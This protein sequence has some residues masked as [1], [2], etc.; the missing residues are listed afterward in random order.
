MCA[1]SPRLGVL[2]RLRPVPTRSVDGGPTPSHPRRQHGGRAG[3]E[4]VPVSTDDSLDEGGARLRPC[5]IAT[6][7]PQHFTEASRPDIH[8]PARKFPTEPSPGGCAPRPAH[9]RQVGAGE[10]LRDVPT[11]VPPVLLSVTL[12]GPTPS[13]G[14]GAS[15]LCQGCSHPPRHLPRQ[16]ALSFNRPAATRR[17]RRSLTSVQNVSASRRTWIEA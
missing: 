7:T 2:R 5:G 10:P 1:G 14:A 17:R 3:A 6:A 12:A 16:A 8:M 15:R 13:D 4:T 11:L 9:I